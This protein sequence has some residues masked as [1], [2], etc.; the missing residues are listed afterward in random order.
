MANTSILRL[1]YR[2]EQ[3]WYG[4]T[5]SSILNENVIV[6]GEREIMRGDGGIRKEVGNLRV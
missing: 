3:V 5:T 1:R 2:T 6:F 4:I